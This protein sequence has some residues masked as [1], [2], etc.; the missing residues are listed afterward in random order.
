[1]RGTKDIRLTRINIKYTWITKIFKSLFYKRKKRMRYK[2]E[3]YFRWMPLQW[4]FVCARYGFY[5]SICIIESSCNRPEYSRIRF[6]LIESITNIWLR[7]TL[8][9][10]SRSG[11]RCLLNFTCLNMIETRQVSTFLRNVVN[12]I[13]VI[14]LEYSNYIEFRLY[15][16]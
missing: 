10:C 2:T 4:N 8:E 13:T 5:H 14:R 15:C 11:S 6:F 16:Q 12:K 9:Q 1:M 3:H 7:F